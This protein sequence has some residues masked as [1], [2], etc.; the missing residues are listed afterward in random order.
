MN[1]RVAIATATALLSMMINC[2]NLMAHLNSQRLQNPLELGC[3]WMLDFN[4]PLPKRKSNQDQRE[5]KQLAQFEAEVET[6][7]DYYQVCGRW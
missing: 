5:A 3:L 7:R 4:T 2:S 1:L 6:R